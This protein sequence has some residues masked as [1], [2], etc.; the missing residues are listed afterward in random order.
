MFRQISDFV[1][2]LQEQECYEN[3]TIILSGDHLT[4][5]QN[6]INN[7]EISQDYKR[8]VYTTIINSACHY[9]LGYDR[10]FAVFD[11]YP[12]TLA[13]MGVKVEGDRLGLGVNLYSD[14][15]T[16]VEKMGLDKLNSEL[17]KKSV[18]YDEK[19]K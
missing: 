3:T 10:E 7:K 6:Y 9:D 4:M 1:K 19:L 13:A 14:I 11:L 17:E 12:T 15:P 16:L 2:W 8:R 18:Y 5:D